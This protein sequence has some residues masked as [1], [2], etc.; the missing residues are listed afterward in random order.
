[1]GKVTYAI[2][3]KNELPFEAEIKQQRRVYNSLKIKGNYL[4]AAETARQL[5]ETLL[6]QSDELAA[7]EEDLEIQKKSLT[8]ALDYCNEA[9]CFYDSPDQYKELLSVKYISIKCLQ[10]L[11]KYPEALRSCQQQESLVQKFRSDDHIVRQELFKNF[12]DIY[13]NR[14][15]DETF[16]IVDDFQNAKQY[17]QLEREALLAI[18]EKAN[19]EDTEELKDLVRANIFNL[20]VVECKIYGDLELADKLLREAIEQARLLMDLDSERNAWWE[21][22]N[23]YKMQDKFEKALECQFHELKLAQLDNSQATE[24]LCLYD[25]AV[26]YLEMG[27]DEK[28]LEIE[29]D[30]EALAN[31]QTYATELIEQLEA[32]RTTTR[33]AQHALAVTSGNI[34]SAHQ[35]MSLAK[36]YEQVSMYAKAIKALSDCM[37]C[38]KQQQTNDLITLKLKFECNLIRGDL[39]W[40]MK[41]SVCIQ[42]LP[43][44]EIQDAYSQF[45]QSLSELVEPFLTAWALLE[46]ASAMEEADELRNKKLKIVKNLLRIHDYYCMPEECL[47]WQSEYQDIAR[48]QGTSKRPSTESFS[49]DEEDSSLEQPSKIARHSLPEIS[50]VTENSNDHAGPSIIKSH[51]SKV[52]EVRVISV[53][54][55]RKLLVPWS[56]NNNTVQW[57]MDEVPNRCWILFGELPRISHMESRGARLFPGDVLSHIF[58]DNL[59]NVSAFVEDYEPRSFSDLYVNACQR[60]GS[61][62][63]EDI[64]KLLTTSKPSSISLFGLGLSASDVK[65]LADTLSFSETIK[66][67]DLSGNSI[68]DT[69][70]RT[71]FSA[72]DDRP[73]RIMPNLENLNLAC[74]NIGAESVKILLIALPTCMQELDLSHNPIGYGAVQLLPA[75]ATRF[76]MLA[77]LSLENCDLDDMAIMHSSVVDNA[78]SVELSARRS[79]LIISL[80]DNCMKQHT[81][82]SFLALLGQIP[83]VRQLSMP[84][85]SKQIVTFP[86][87]LLCNIKNV[88]TL[89]ISNTKLH[90]SAIS[91]L[92]E[93]L[94]ASQCLITLD[95]AY[96][97]I[98]SSHMNAVSQALKNS[99]SI[100]EVNLTGNKIEGTAI[101]GMKNMTHSSY[102]EEPLFLE[103]LRMSDC[104]IEAEIYDLAL[105]TQ[106]FAHLILTHNMVISSTVELE[107]ILNAMSEQHRA[108]QLIIDA[109]VKDVHIERIAETRPDL[110]SLFNVQRHPIRK[111]QVTAVRL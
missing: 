82:E 76:P 6:D 56:D 88:Q 91:S 74:N 62:C 77:K 104:G 64:I 48:M 24:L 57:L 50:N 29:N 79:G 98:N 84:R 15:A 18:Q 10:K 53:T 59:A 99:S 33:Q 89:D 8:K 55:E 70:I 47:K 100:K 90:D 63:D 103:R 41:K 14:G 7:L 36:V 34:N 13:F 67:L 80:G 87:N 20:G 102:E 60:H 52:I 26:T 35:Y 96:C 17:Y 86:G 21:L 44:Y 107:Y 65:P 16:C 106:H 105:W 3:F 38:L 11:Q 92:C 12:A 71:L 51:K 4:K 83:D 66:H 109:S 5:A 27:K 68:D 28:S 37:S 72:D 85:I 45:F 25:I 23:M 58:S 111:T 43:R 69:G 95:L 78:S 30:I 42:T 101:T 61:P 75:L 54:H 110:W 31:D 39:L 22:G 73:N 46:N 2:G 40:K 19:Y 32:V 97:G 94:N 49:S 108:K 1:M 93:V 9:A 81:L